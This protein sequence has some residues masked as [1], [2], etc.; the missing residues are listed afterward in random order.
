MNLVVVILAIYHL[1]TYVLLQT[2]LKTSKISYVNPDGLSDAAPKLPSIGQVK[3]ILKSLNSRKATG[4]DNI[5]PWTIKHFAEEL[6]VVIH[7]LI[8]ESINEC[9]YPSLYKQALVSA[10]PKVNPPE[11]IE[12][13]FRQISILP[14]LGKV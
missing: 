12:T 14:V 10:V 8:C 6:A 9:K 13:D 2:D 1:K 5:S 4:V 3:K 7:D 11:N